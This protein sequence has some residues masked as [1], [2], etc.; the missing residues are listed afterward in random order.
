MLA[1][2]GCTIF[3]IVA[4]VGAYFCHEPELFF[5]KNSQVYIVEPSPPIIPEQKKLSEAFGSTHASESQVSEIVPKSLM[6]KDLSY[7]YDFVEN[8][9]YK[10]AERKD[11]DNGVIILKVRSRGSVIN[12]IFEE[13]DKIQLR[14]HFDRPKEFNEVVANEWNKKFRWTK[15]YIDNDD[16]LVLESDIAIPVSEFY[17]ETIIQMLG[18]FFTAGDIF[19]VWMNSTSD[20]D[21]QDTKRDI[22]SGE[23]EKQI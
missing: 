20:D 9:G 12:V 17:S 3:M 19:V 15:T 8:E 11:F 4:V 6:A 10:I 21:Y 1:L 22:S 14:A 2:Q 18:R 7:F 13:D 23:K 16:D 5:E